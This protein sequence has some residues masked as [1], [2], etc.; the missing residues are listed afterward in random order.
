M[1]S[2]DTPRDLK[3]LRMG[4]TPKKTVINQMHSAFRPDSEVELCPG[5]L[6][7]AFEMQAFPEDGLNVQL[8]GISPDH[9]SSTFF[10][11]SDS[12]YQ[13]NK[14][15][16]TKVELEQELSEADNF[17]F[18]KITS[19]HITNGVLKI[20]QFEYVC[21]AGGLVLAPGYTSHCWLGETFFH[22]VF[23]KNPELQTETQTPVRRVLRSR[24]IFHL[25]LLH[26]NF[27]SNFLSHFCSTFS[28][29]M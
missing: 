9:T 5:A 2:C 6:R 1:G 22:R 3:K 19:A 14:V 24:F 18:I 12:L 10:K 28:S 25:L 7:D 11:I 23:S 15:K 26:I 29:H 27:P 16:A 20:D 17:T 8:L 13:S 21:G 4:E